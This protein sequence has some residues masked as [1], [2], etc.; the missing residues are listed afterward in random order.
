MRAPVILPIFGTA[1]RAWWVDD[2]VLAGLP[3]RARDR[4]GNAGAMVNFLILGSEAA[5]HAGVQRRGMGDR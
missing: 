5:M 4:Q 1:L 2:V 3:R